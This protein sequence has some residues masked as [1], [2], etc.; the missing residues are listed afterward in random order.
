MGISGSMKQYY[1]SLPLRSPLKLQTSPEMLNK[2]H[3]YLQINPP[4]AARFE[5]NARC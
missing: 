2:M 4:L 1:I 5:G 3:R